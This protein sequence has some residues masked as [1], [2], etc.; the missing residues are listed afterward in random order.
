MWASRSA[1]LTSTIIVF[2]GELDLNIYASLSPACFPQILRYCGCPSVYLT[3]HSRSGRINL[4]LM[5]QCSSGSDMCQ[6][7]RQRT[8]IKGESR[9]FSRPAA[10][11][12]MSSSG[13]VVRVGMP[14]FVVFFGCICSRNV[15]G[16]FGGKRSVIEFRSRVEVINRHS[17]LVGFRVLAFPLAGRRRVLS[18]LV[19]GRP[20]LTVVCLPLLVPD[21]LLVDNG[22]IC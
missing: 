22:E 7:S 2:Q 16:L 3:M 13:V 21:I 20:V 4:R 19:I 14:C 17:L 15:Q 5:R 8:F 12:G 6:C 10:A 11:P 1:T 18:S 9:H